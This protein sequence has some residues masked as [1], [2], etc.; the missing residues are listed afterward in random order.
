KMGGLYR[1][2]PI[3]AITMLIGVIAISGLAIPVLNIGFSGFYSKDEIL[4]SGLAFM[5]GNSR[6]FL[7]F[8]VPLVTAGITAFYMFRL[9]FMT[10]AGPPKDQHVYEHAHESPAVMTGPLIVLSVVAIGAGWFGVLSTWLLTSEPAHLAEGVVAAQG[11][12]PLNMPGHA[13]IHAPENHGTAGVAALI[14]AV[15]GA[16]LSAVFY[17]KRIVDPETIRRQ[18]A[19]VHHFLVEKWQ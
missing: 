9:W 6:H 1:K 5:T 8:F 2:M 17:W 13:A 18:V 16:V 3:T 4:A 19:G 10:F 11:H 15:I 12:L 14:A 7:L